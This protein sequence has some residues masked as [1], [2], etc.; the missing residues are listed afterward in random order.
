MTLIANNFPNAVLPHPATPLPPTQTPSRTRR[1]RCGNDI[2]ICKN[3]LMIG[4]RKCLAG[5]GVSAGETGGET[6]EVRTA[7]QR[8]SIG[9]NERH[10]LACIVLT[11]IVKIRIAKDARMPGRPETQR[12]LSRHLR[13]QRML[14]DHVSV[15][16]SSLTGLSCPDR[17]VSR[18]L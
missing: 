16:S 18:L 5:R 11:C 7:R 12:G 6:P 14:D 4:R 3:I 8:L 2:A 1:G 9:L 17:G 13:Q 15:S 10:T